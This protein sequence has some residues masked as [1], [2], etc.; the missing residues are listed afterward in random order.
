MKIK[1]KMWVKIKAW[2]INSPSIR[3]GLEYQH[4]LST[5]NLDWSKKLSLQM[6]TRWLSLHSVVYLYSFS[7]WAASL[8][9]SL[10]EFT[11]RTSKCTKTS[12][13][14]RHKETMKVR[15]AQVPLT[16]SKIDRISIKKWLCFK[17]SMQQLLSSRKAQVSL[18]TLIEPVNWVEWAQSLKKQV[19][20]EIRSQR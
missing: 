8:A 19:K 11:N 7:F 10:Y 14:H 12:R 3:Q 6:E 17:S 1:L 18:N 2:I 4:K 20:W 16:G 13:K 9:F 15:E 5:I